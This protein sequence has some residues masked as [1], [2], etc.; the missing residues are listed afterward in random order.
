ML[1]SE[2]GAQVTTSQLMTFD[3]AADIMNCA[4]E[5][6]CDMEICELYIAMVTF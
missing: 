2:L 1:S 5:V 6:N 4:K 3:M